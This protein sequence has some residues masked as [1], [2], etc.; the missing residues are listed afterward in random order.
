MLS[1]RRHPSQEEPPCYHEPQPPSAETFAALGEHPR[2]PLSIL[3][4]SPS[5][6]VHRSALAAVLHLCLDRRPRL[7]CE[8]VFIDAKG[9]LKLGHFLN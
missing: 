3:P 8:F 7:E 9:W 2:D 5:R 4:F 6:L 1:H